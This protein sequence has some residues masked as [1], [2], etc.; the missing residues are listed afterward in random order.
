MMN[1]DNEGRDPRLIGSYLVSMRAITP[2]Q[3]KYGLMLSAI[4]A[5]S[6]TRKPIGE[7]LIE[8]GLIKQYQ[9][10]RA[11]MLQ[12]EDLRRQ[13]VMEAN[14]IAMPRFRQ[15]GEDDQRSGFHFVNTRREQE[16]VVTAWKRGR[17]IR[18]RTSDKQ[19]SNED[20]A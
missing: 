11:L 19:S 8:A 5:V 17:A 6:G 7:T 13:E 14:R 4:M 20:V 9:L 12:A 1:S 3:L 15:Q 16:D 2:E 10:D 18:K